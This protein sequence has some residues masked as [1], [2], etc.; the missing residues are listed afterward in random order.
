MRCD[1]CQ[2]VFFEFFL[3][4][5]LEKFKFIDSISIGRSLIEEAVDIEI[6]LTKVTNILTQMHTFY[7]HR[8]L[9]QS[10]IKIRLDPDVCR[11]LT[12]GANK[13]DEVREKV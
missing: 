6:L 13:S 7:T 8:N 12:F 5:P 2:R 10:H 11:K 9:K 4:M 3:D 1:R